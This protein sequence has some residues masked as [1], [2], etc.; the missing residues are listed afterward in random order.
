M[1]EPVAGAVAWVVVGGLVLYAKSWGW[2]TESE[3]KQSAHSPPPKA[4]YSRSQRMVGVVVLL[5]VLAVGLVMGIIA[6][7]V[8]L[9]HVP[10][11]NT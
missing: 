9:G 1:L 3:R 4:E 2:T 11:W 8:A 10:T 6:I 7:F 5:I